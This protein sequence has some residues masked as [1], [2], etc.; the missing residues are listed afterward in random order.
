MPLTALSALQGSRR[1]GS[2][3]KDSPA[4]FPGKHRALLARQTPHSSA[5]GPMEL[6]QQKAFSPDKQSL[7]RRMYKLQRM[8]ITQTPEAGD[9]QATAGCQ[10]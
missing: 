3:R 6:R 10:S 7:Q 2:A 8:Q 9:R 4:G 5:P 1:R